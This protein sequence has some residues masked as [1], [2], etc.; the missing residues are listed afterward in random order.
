MKVHLVSSRSQWKKHLFMIDESCYGAKGKSVIII[1][2]S[3]S[4]ALTY[5]VVFSQVMD[6]DCYRLIL[7]STTWPNLDFMPQKG[8]SH[9][10]AKNHDPKI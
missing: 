6:V 7:A 10:L 1:Q 5:H 2:R 9:A 8:Y 3:A 4:S